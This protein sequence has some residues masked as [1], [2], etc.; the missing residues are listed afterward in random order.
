MCLTEN[1]IVVDGV[2]DETAVGT[3]VTVQLAVQLLVVVALALYV[4]R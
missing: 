3:V 2:I 4:R 1:R